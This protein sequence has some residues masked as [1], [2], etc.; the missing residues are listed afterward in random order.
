MT[1]TSIFDGT[2]SLINDAL[3]LQ[4]GQKLKQK[5]TCLRLKP[6][7]ISVEALA[8]LV[9]D[10]RGRVFSNWAGRQPSVENWRMKRVTTLSEI[11]KS[12]EV[13]LERAIAILGEKGA[14][15]EWYNQVPVA[16]GMIDD[17]ANKRAA[18][19]LIR[20]Q[21]RRV[22]LVELKWGSDTPVFAAFEILQYG[23]AYLLCR[24][25]KDIFKYGDK[26]LMGAEIISLQVLAPQVF[27]KS[28]DLGFLS[29]G[30]HQ[31]L[32]RLCERRTDGLQMSFQ[33]LAFPEG[34]QLPFSS[35]QDVLEHLNGPI[36][37][38]PNQI[39]IE[40][41]NNLQPL[42]KENDL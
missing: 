3:G 10:L 11:N 24:D 23:L 34:F 40:A 26:E 16:S 7:V 25:N 42:W 27:Y 29:A 5:S 18:V 30:I 1:A 38:G 17:R 36:E 37:E 33:F 19:D 6:E 15:P 32:N 35:G 28:Y 9:D 8:T 4:D 21:G 39:L 41:L 14:L 2:E 12:P 20:V 13:V 22:D 31:G